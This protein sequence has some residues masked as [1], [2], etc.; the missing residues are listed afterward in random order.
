M[1][2]NQNK[3]G[4]IAPSI[5]TLFQN[6]QSNQEIKVEQKDFKF[7]FTSSLLDENRPALVEEPLNLDEVDSLLA[8]MDQAA[9]SNYFH[10]AATGIISGGP[11]ERSQK[12]R[13]F[14]DSYDDH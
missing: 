7:N 14:L 5:N 8:E 12:S 13:Y 3:S 6:N 9:G 11:A 10:Q 4:G 1:L 2:L